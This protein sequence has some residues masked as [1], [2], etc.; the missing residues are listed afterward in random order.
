MRS[1]MSDRD[2]S[3]KPQSSRP[4]MAAS[5]D[6]ELPSLRGFLWAVAWVVATILIVTQYTIAA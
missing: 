2:T 4:L 6:A 5:P 3:E 1:T